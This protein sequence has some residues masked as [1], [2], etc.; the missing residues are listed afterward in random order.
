M[1]VLAHIPLLYGIHHLMQHHIIP[2][3][4]TDMTAITKANI[5]DTMAMAEIVVHHLHIHDVVPLV[6]DQEQDRIPHVTKLY[7]RDIASV[8]E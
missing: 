1:M 7:R 2:L 5:M 6:I 4:M 3:I 8:Q